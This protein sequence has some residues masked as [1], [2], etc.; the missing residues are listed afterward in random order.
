MAHTV[1]DSQARVRDAFNKM[2]EGI[3]KDIIRQRQVLYYN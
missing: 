3:D 1:E 2:M